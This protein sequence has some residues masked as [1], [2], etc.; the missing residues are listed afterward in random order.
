MLSEFLQINEKR[1]SR[2][3]FSEAFKEIDKY[4][5]AT[6]T[7]FYSEYGK[8]TPLSSKSIKRI[9][10]K[11]KNFNVVDLLF[12]KSVIFQKSNL[13]ESNYSN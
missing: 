11:F 12:W 4:G 2:R 10:E 6:I 5:L 1:N 7:L 3:L 9:S 13:L 8:I